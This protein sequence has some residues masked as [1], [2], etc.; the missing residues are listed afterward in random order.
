MKYGLVTG[1]GDSPAI[2]AAIRSI[3]ENAYRKDDQIVGFKNGWAGLLEN[4]VW[5]LTREDVSGILKEG[6]SI[7]G[8]SRTDPFLEEKNTQ[9]IKDIYEDIHRL[10]GLIA[11]G[12][13]D[14]LGVAHRLHEE[15]NIGVVG[16]PQTIDNDVALTRCSIGFDTALNGVM[17]AADELHTTATTH[18]RVM[19]LEV[20]GRNAGWLA[21]PGGISG[22]ADIIL[23]PEET[24]EISEIKRK[25]KQRRTRGKDFSIVVIA[26]GATPE[27][28]NQQVG[29]EGAESDDEFQHAKYGGIGNALGN[30]LKEE[31]ELTVRVTQ[32]GYLQRGGT[33][34]ARDRLLA[35][36]YGAEA[37]E[38]CS[39]RQF[40]KM[41]A[42][43]SNQFMEIQAVDLEE[44]IDKSPRKLHSPLLKLK[45]LFL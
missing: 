6:G 22:G 45:D 26:E 8:S 21:A 7:L 33:P 44:V 31:L 13:D 3:V 23:V 40:D 43:S 24:F 28:F 37:V 15:F 1:G 4:D 38:L 29:Q 36:H 41:V 32:L 30:R 34:T 5:L 12:G 19:I 27:D 10:K 20:M 11:I 39:N 14:T 9:K 16:V 18:H 35:T 25:I 42:T 17:E 2:N